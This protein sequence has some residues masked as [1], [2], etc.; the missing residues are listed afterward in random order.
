ME[1][2]LI[3]TRTV[4]YAA[5]AALAGGAD[6]LVVIAEPAFRVVA[7]RDADAAALRRDV[8]RILWASLALG[9]V[10]GALWL[11]LEA[12]DMSGRPFAAVFARDIIATV[13]FRTQFGSD[14]LARLAMAVALVPALLAARRS[15]A[16][17]RGAR[18]LA[19]VLSAALLGAL[20]WAGHAGATPGEEGEVHLVS[21]V[22]H[23]LA[24]GAWLGGLLPLILLFARSRG[25]PALL[26]VTRR[27]TRRFS[28]LGLLSVATLLATGI[29]NSV[30]LVGTVPGLLG[31]LYGQLLLAKIAGFLVMVTVAAINRQRLTPA[32]LAD[33]APAMAL[34]RL[35]RNALIETALGLAILTIV[36][37]IGTLPP[38]EHTEPVWPLPFRL[39]P[40]ALK[41]DF[42]TLLA[43]VMVALGF[44]AL[45]HAALRRR[46][47]WLSAALGVGL[48]IG[49]AWHP[50]AE[51]A[52]PAYPTTYF[53]PTVA[54]SA[55]SVSMGARVFAANCALCH[56]ADGRGD[57]P[58]AASLPIKPTDLTQAHVL[59]HNPGDLYWWISTGRGGVMPGF[60]GTLSEHQRWNVIN[61][62]RTRAA[63]AQPRSLMPQV[64]PNP[65]PAAPD[66][67]FEQKGHQGTLRQ[68][69]TR[70]AVLLVLYRLPEAAARLK[71]LA[72]AETPLAQAGLRLLALPI[73]SA[74]RDA[75]SGT[76]LPDF[77][78]TSDAATAAAFRLFEGAGEPD[79]CEFL[80]DRA[81]FLRARWCEGGAAPLPDRAM[82]LVEL[83]RMAR[84][85][86][87]QQ[88]AHVHAH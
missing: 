21:D 65:A 13:L 40:E 8:L 67:T 51:I 50:I 9:L 61:F 36:G 60:A 25:A 82:L 70:S 49:F 54:Y 62:V 66:F 73:G 39:V 77:T 47:R 37:V 68:A 80:I 71:R 20:A 75:E 52:E 74:P 55:A 33:A 72:A 5:L 34:M 24:A 43:G 27:A 56:G 41:P 23:L 2:W 28:W 26:A 58:V 1:P 17:G 84:M 30:I 88:A 76:A 22:L 57:G 86:L 81:G 38:G 6:F 63:A 79:D 31:T 12:R 46:G 16:S 3:L 59:G 11:V 69:L 15:G 53:A 87:E 85:P 83:A 35:R 32:L 42:A 4:H 44:A 64:T 78:A 18:G 48:V 45:L 19:L 7:G 29:V 10:S 14:W